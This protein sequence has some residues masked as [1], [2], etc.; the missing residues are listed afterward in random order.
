[1]L[2][3]T[4]PDT[5]QPGARLCHVPITR[6]SRN[7]HVRAQL[8][9]AISVQSTDLAD[10]GAPA[11]DEQQPHTFCLVPVPQSQPVLPC[12]LRRQLQHAHFRS[13]RRLARLHQHGPHF[14]R[15][16][17]W[18]LFTALEFDYSEGDVES[19]A[20]GAALPQ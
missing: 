7:R 9:P 6:R 2:P 8:Q 15:S 10:G 11:R 1:M 17:E 4:A 3:C 18:L 5:V 12:L 19:V 16:L 14:S 13:A 20:S